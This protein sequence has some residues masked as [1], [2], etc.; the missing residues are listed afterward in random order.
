MAQNVFAVEK[1][2]SI[3]LGPLTPEMAKRDLGVLLTPELAVNAS[4]AKVRVAEVEEEKED[5]CDRTESDG[6]AFRSE[7]SRLSERRTTEPE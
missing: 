2:F 7:M 1:P 4:E 5:V 3:I 6:L